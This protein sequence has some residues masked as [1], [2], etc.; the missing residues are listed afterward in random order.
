MTEQKNREQP[1]T[2]PTMALNGVKE[3]GVVSEI[4]SLNNMGKFKTVKALLDAYNNLQSEFTRKCQKIKEYEKDKIES[5]NLTSCENEKNL[6]E[7]LESENCEK[8]NF[9]EEKKDD[10]KVLFEKEKTKQECQNGRQQEMK[11]ENKDNDEEK[12]LLKQENLLQF[13]NQN[14]L[15]KN[16]EDEIVSL[17]KE[18]E[19]QNPFELAWAKIVFSHLDKNENKASDPIINQY[20]INDDNVKNKIIENYLEELNSQKPPITISSQ[21]GERVCGVIP[22]HPQTLEEAKGIVKQMFS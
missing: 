5:E 22:K 2:E 8:S 15:A 13:L 16:Y 19:N 9:D 14:N 20:V 4:G 12:S 18:S 1:I 11:I 7:N 10:E 21:K 6:N 17:S 3:N